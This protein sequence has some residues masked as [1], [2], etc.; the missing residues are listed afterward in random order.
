[1][2]ANI[3]LCVTVTS[4]A[5]AAWA[6]VPV[7]R[8]W[9]VSNFV[10]CVQKPAAQQESC[11]AQTGLLRDGRTPE[12]LRALFADTQAQRQREEEQRAAAVAAQYTRELN[13]CIERGSIP[14]SEVALVRAQKIQLGM[15]EAA[16]LCSWGR[17]ERVNRSVGSWGEHKQYIYSGANVYV[18]N[19]KVT[20]WQD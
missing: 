10:Y 3:G 2:R 11:F 20:S 14:A 9:E 5:S 7:L 12:Q 1:M 17:P 18:E 19:G 4:L 8:D 13:T 16:L 15:S 6:Q